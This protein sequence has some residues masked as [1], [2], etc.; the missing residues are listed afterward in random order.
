MLF[1]DT[2]ECK[3]CSALE[4]L[5]G[6]GRHHT[7]GSGHVSSGKVSRVDV[8]CSGRYVRVHTHLGNTV[9]LVPDHCSTVSITEK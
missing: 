2:K 1:R 8:V 9:G 6:Y 5:T 3:M 7:G 4:E